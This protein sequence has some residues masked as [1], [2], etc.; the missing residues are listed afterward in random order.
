MKKNVIVV[1]V[2]LLLALL[3]GCLFFAADKLGKE[4]TVVTPSVNVTPSTEATPSAG[5]DHAAD[6]TPTNTPTPADSAQLT[7]TSAP[8]EMPTPEPTPSE[9]P[10]NTPTPTPE[11]SQGL[12]V[13][14]AMELLCLV[15]ADELRLPED[16]SAYDLEADDWTTMIRGKECY[17]INVLNPGGGL[18]GM[19]Y[20]ALDA[21]IGYRVDETGGF[22]AISLP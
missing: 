18:A 15:S 3:L 7:P 2:V 6:P 4:K 5:G 13:Q 19:F 17:C 14:E 20:I 10:T 12:S 11:Q 21:S 1:G 22:L 8:S 16:I 9:T